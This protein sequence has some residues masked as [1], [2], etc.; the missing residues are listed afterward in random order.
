MRERTGRPGTVSPP[1]VKV[2]IFI[3]FLVTLPYQPLQDTLE[4]KVHQVKTDPRVT[5]EPRELLE[6]RANREGPG[7]MVSMVSM[8]REHLMDFR[9]PRDLPATRALTAVM[10]CKVRLVR[11]DLRDLWD[12]MVRKVSL[13][14]QV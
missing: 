1:H 12:L 6:S 9:D 7:V 4:S 8:V 5:L 14:C 10:G 13:A 11:W 3:Y 2:G